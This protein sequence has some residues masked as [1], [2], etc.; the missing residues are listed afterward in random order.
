MCSIVDF[1]SVVFLTFLTQ[2]SHMLL[3]GELAGY[4]S[5]RRFLWLLLLLF[6]W[7]G[8]ALVSCHSEIIKSGGNL[9]VGM[10][11]GLLFLFIYFQSSRCSSRSGFLFVL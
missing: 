6:C 11:L 3:L 10:I 4:R 8:V 7:A 9:D 5:H 1:L 2:V